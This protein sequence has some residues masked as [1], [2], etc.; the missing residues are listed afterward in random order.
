MKKLAILFAVVFV[1]GA[2]VGMHGTSA[3]AAGSSNCYWTCICSVPYKCCT[4]STGTR[5]KVDL[6]APIGCPQVAC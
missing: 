2:V 3:N 1:L 5:C 4:S 6:N